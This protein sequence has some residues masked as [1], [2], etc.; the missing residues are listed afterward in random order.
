MSFLTTLHS[1]RASHLDFIHSAG[2]GTLEREYERG[3]LTHDEFYALVAKYDDL[4]AEMYRAYD[5]HVDAC[6][7]ELAHRSMCRVRLLKKT[8]KESLAL[9]NAPRKDEHDIETS[10][11]TRT[12][13][14][15]AHAPPQHLATQSG[16]AQVIT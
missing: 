5:A 10:L 7:K 8:H 15:H 1:N 14:L 4:E 12:S 6:K 13:S 11:E 9:L 16:A 2:R 3:V